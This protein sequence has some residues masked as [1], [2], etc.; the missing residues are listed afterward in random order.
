MTPDLVLRHIG[1]LKA[2]VT[3]QQVGLELVLSQLSGLEA[4]VQQA[5]QPRA[6]IERPERCQA[7]HESDCARL[8]EE[9]VLELGGMGGTSVT[10]MCRGCGR[11]P[12]ETT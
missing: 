4:Y 2:S 3:Q 11:D 12:H 8:N 9:A 7:H 1:A 10:L 6:R 5:M